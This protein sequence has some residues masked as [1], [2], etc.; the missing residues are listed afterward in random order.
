MT[1][2]TIGIDFGTASGRAVLVDTA[3]GRVVATATSDYRT[4]SST[5]R[6]PVDGP[7]VRLPPDWALQDPA[8]Y[9]DVIRTTVPEVLARSGRRPAA[10]SS[11]SASTSR[12]ARCC[13]P[14]PTGRRS[15]RS[16]GWRREP[17]AWVKLWKH[18]AAQPE[19]DRIND[20]ARATGQPWLDRYGGRISSEW[21]FSKILQ[22]LDESPEVYA[23]AERFIEATDWIVW[24]LTGTETRNACTAGYK[25]MWSKRDGFPDRVVLRGPRPAAGRR[26]RDQDVERHPSRRWTRRRAEPRRPRRGPACRSGPPSP[27]ATSMPMSPSRP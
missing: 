15:P 2:Y 8:D 23:A 1:S 24:Q 26:R 17:H 27:S 12:P 10:R 20:T 13:R 5:S 18:H 11:A 4:A 9:L 3:D 14:S 25:A 16:T 19:A 21:F 7:T 22:V 6:L